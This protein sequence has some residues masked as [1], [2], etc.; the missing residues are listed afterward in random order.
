[1]ISYL[2]R[3][4]VAV[5]QPAQDR[6]LS[7]VGGVPWGMPAELWPMCC[8]HPQKLFAQLVHEPPMLDLGEDGAVL[9]LFQ[10]ADCLG[11][12]GAE[13]C[14]AF[15]VP[16]ARMG[17]GLVT[18]PDYDHDGGLGGRLNGELW[19]TGWTPFD[20]GIDASRLPEFYDEPKLWKLQE[21]FDYIDWFDGPHM[22]RAGGAPRW[23]GNGPQSVPPKPYEFLMQID[24]GLYPRSELPADDVA[25]RL[26]RNVD[27]P[28]GR[29]PKA[30]P[31]WSLDEAEDRPGYLCA[32]HANLGS[33]GTAYVFVD[34]TRTPHRFT[35]FWNR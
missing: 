7:K 13:G 15:L 22:T 31:P 12:D 34:R 11:V 19:V 5:L 33:D 8:G 9:H 29:A 6:L 32:E 20:D 4:A 3:W 26:A 16:R 25:D 30:V 1:M 10:C 17:K 28:H 35:W 2:P 24:S 21:E 23:T 14:A 27:L 18:T